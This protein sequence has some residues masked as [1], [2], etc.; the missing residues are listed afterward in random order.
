[1]EYKKKTFKNGLR[2]VVAPMQDARSVTL[3]ALFGT[4][5]KY[6]EKSINGVSHFLEHL[7]FKGT[8]SRPKPNQIKRDLDRLGAQSNAFTS[9]EYTGYY[10]KAATKFFDT[11][12]DIV[13]DIL[14]EP[15]FNAEE[16]E[17]ERGVILQELSMYED[18]P[19]RHSYELFETLLYGD[20]PAGWD[21]GG[22]PDTVK[23]IKR[24]DILKY[25]TSHY[26]AR[27]AV[28]VVA[29]N[30]DSQEAFLKIEKAFS[31]IPDGKTPKKLRVKELQKK[32][33]VKFKKKD[34][35]Q[36]HIR[37]GV[38]ALDMYSKQRFALGV[39][40]TIIGGN[41]SSRLFEE[42]REKLGL[43]YYVRTSA[44]QYTDSGYLLAAAGVPHEKTEIAVSKIVKIFHD[45]RTKGVTSQEIKFAKEY[46][47]GSLALTFESTDEVAIYMASQE[48]FHKTIE[49]PEDT[50]LK[51]EAVTKNDIIKVARDIF[52]PSK[53]NFAAVG[54]NEDVKKIE[55]ILSN[56]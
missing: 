22:Y 52:R 17:K 21:T 44:E 14:T 36:T 11:G 15:L 39:L 16:I 23:N 47:R 25:R 31:G 29:G 20:Q 30:I 49:M 51:I 38:R 41:W 46:I 40:E 18:D 42:L 2:A 13:S 4:G 37:I 9:K 35:D 55:K 19:M 48:L 53:I 56:V 32:P 33:M 12:L 27:N 43:T 26:K 8:K 24:N 45:V 7:F 10:V 1:M 6:E 5:S 50:L 3:V 34:V 54:P 28:I